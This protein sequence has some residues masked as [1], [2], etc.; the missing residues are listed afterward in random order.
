MNKFWSGV[1]LRLRGS[2]RRVV[3][4]CVSAACLALSASVGSAAIQGNLEGPN[5]SEIA[6]GIANV[7]GWV[8]PTLPGDVIETELDVYVDGQFVMNIPCCGDRGD[9]KQAHPQAPMLSGFSG[10]YNF[11]S[12]T[13]GTHTMEVHAYSKLGDHKVLST[14][15][16]SA[17]LGSYAYN[18]KFQ[19]DDAKADHCTASN[20]TVGGK[21][22][23][24]VVCTDVEFTNGTGYTEHCAGTVEM[25]WMSSSQGFRVTKGC[26]F[27]DKVTPP[28]QINPELIGKG[29]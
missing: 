3:I 23:A 28:F 29:F 25:T 20:T 8:F 10:A 13:P 12:L 26:D 9:V 14:T 2:G 19:W 22:V 6:S 24:R 27:I 21:T 15:F 7:Q 1:A 18:K 16:D 17:R 5:G 4:A 11:S